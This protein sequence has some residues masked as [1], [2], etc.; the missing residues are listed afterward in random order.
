MS[1]KKIQRNVEDI[2]LL[3][4]EVNTFLI[5]SKN[6]IVC[7]SLFNLHHDTVYS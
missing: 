7:D 6:F 5:L 2:S 1:L 4:E 3:L